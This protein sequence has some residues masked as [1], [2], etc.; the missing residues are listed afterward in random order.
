MTILE[1]YK[2]YQIMPQL[3]EH[4]LR[5]AAVAEAILNHLSLI[6][7]A[8]DIVAACLLHDMGNILKFDL[9]KSHLLLNKEIDVNFWQKVKEEY[10]Q[11]Y[12]EDEHEASMKIARELNVS[13]RVIELVDAIGFETAAGNAASQ[14][15]GK[16]ICAYADDR[17][18]PKS[19]VTLEQRFLDLRARYAHRHQ[20]WGNE[21]KRINFEESLRTIERQIFEHCQIKP[22]DITEEAIAG[23]KERLKDFE[24]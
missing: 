3:Q 9:A 4:Q 2:K 22:E 5:V 14:D 21:Q 7:N 19:V 24:I 11:K 1:I 10:R 17:V 20:E 12:G 15:L 13:Q 16:K 23:R 8:H 6:L 18:S